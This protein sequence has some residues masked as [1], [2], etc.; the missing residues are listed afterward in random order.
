MYPADWVG[1]PDQ[2]A[3]NGFVALVFVQVCNCICRIC[4]FERDL[5]APC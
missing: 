2:L 3:D 5:D 1:R 4:I